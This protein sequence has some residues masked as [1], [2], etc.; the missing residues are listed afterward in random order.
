MKKL[1][2]NTT[3]GEWLLYWFETY[4][5]PN[6]SA[7]SLRNYEQMLRLHTPQWL[8]D[9]PLYKLTCFDID[10][11]LLNINGGR[12]KVY[13]KQTWHAALKVAWRKGIVKD[14]P[15][16][17]AEPIRY[18]KRH[19]NTL[20]RIE[21][22]DFLSNLEGR[23]EKWLFLFYL[24][25]GV[26]RNEALSIKWSDVNY[27]EGYIRIQGTK[28]AA[29]ARVIPLTKALKEIIRCQREQYEYEKECPPRYKVKTSDEYIFPWTPEVVSDRFKKLCPNHHLHDLRHTYITFCAQNGVNMTVCQRLVGHATINTTLSIYTHVLDEFTREEAEKINFNMPLHTKKED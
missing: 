27:T 3:F 4:K 5:V 6:L 2:K 21:I 25:S 8:K 13:A 29:S 18:K 24:N 26:R 19:G 17:R 7:T 11:A 28:T 10:E 12:T 14:N 22:E 1:D 16:E 23:R 15:V 20:T 9:I